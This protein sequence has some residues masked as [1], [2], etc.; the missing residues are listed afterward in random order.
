MPDDINMVELWVSFHAL[1]RFRKWQTKMGKDETSSNFL[2]LEANL[3]EVLVASTPL[4]LTD[5]RNWQDHKRKYPHS[6]YYR[7]ERLVLVVDLKEKVVVTCF[8][9]VGRGATRR[10]PRF[11]VKDRARGKQALRR[12]LHEGREIV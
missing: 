1:K 6:T 3:R 5:M 11:R 10:K 9:Y 2:L 12:H 4:K 8:L 7:H